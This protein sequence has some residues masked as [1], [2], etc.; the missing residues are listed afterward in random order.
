MGVSNQSIVD[1]AFF[2]DYDDEKEQESLF[3]EQARLSSSFF[4]ELQR[5]SV[6]LEEP[7]IRAINNNSMALDLY[8]WTAFRLHALKGPL[9]I[10]WTA[11]KGQFGTGFKHMTHFRATFLEQPLSCNGGLPGCSDRSY[12]TWPNSQAV[13]TSSSTSFSPNTVG[14]RLH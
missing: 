9:P 5:H 8:A 10:M 12:G 13:A 11:L 4:E 14:F 7:A 6:P 3:P 2:L 1:T